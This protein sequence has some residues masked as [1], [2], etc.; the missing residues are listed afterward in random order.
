M[1]RSSLKTARKAQPSSV[2]VQSVRKAPRRTRGKPTDIDAH[3]GQRVRFRRSLLGMSQEK[4]ATAL[5]LTF[6]QVQKYEKGA[7][8]VG[9]GRLYQLSQA[10]EVPV[11]Y[12]FE[13]LA[14]PSGEKDVLVEADLL[15]R[16]E[17]VDVIRS[18]Y[19]ISDSGVRQQLRD[20]LRTLAG[21]DAA[22]ADEEETSATPG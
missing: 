19:S 3:V 8:R 16:R 4:L 10:L 2:K 11:S 13:G 14:G 22:T 18:Y 21:S 17:T 20:L 6:Q 15:T 12:F 1:M 9:A 5:D 7:N